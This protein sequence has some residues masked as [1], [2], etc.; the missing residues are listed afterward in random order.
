M[1]RAIN[2]TISK[3]QV[4][5]DFH[6]RFVFLSFRAVSCLTEKSDYRHNK[7]LRNRTHFVVHSR[8]ARE[9]NKQTLRLQEVG[10]DTTETQYQV[11]SMKTR[12]LL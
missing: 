11:V 2:P 12:A 3:R 10:T 5:L 8:Q 9:S 7:P 6:H 1:S 4:G